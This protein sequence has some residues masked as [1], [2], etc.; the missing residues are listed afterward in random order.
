MCFRETRKNIF[1]KQL[2]YTTNK[3]N[4]ESYEKGEGIN[5]YVFK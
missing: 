1:E 5:F 4:Y 2:T 3:Q